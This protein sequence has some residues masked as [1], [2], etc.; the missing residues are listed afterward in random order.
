MSLILKAIRK[1]R[2]LQ[3]A[4][5]ARTNPSQPPKK[6][7]DGLVMATLIA[8]CVAI[9]AL[10]VWSASSL[11][12]SINWQTVG[13]V[14]LFAILAG[15]LGLLIYKKGWKSTL[16]LVA[17]VGAILIAI[18]LIRSWQT[19]GEDDGPTLVVT[20][21]WS[22]VIRVPVGQQF[23]LDR[24]ENVAYA[25][26]TQSGNIVR[27]PQDPENDTRTACEKH[28]WI[29]EAVSSFQIIVTEPGVEEVS[30]DLAFT[31]YQRGGPCKIP[32][33]QVGPEVTP[34]PEPPPQGR[35]VV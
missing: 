1:A 8:L 12:T 13:W 4:N 29:Q 27:F 24:R 22:S 35:K 32:D 33:N 16:K 2:Q 3:Q 14:T 15:V 9:A 25:I 20:R 7:S 26:R 11:V 10:L 6:N 28:V 5:Q 18:L 23:I 17:T 30:F 31:T 21:K 19:G 34:A